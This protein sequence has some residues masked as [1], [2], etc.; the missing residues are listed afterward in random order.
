M[1]SFNFEMKNILNTPRM[2]LKDQ[3]ELT[4][5]EAKLARIDSLNCKYINAR[6]ELVTRKRFFLLLQRYCL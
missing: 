4:V 5:G 6:N 1:K 3:F 2:K